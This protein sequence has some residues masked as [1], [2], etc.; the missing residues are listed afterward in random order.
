MDLNEFEARTIVYRRKS[1]AVAEAALDIAREIKRHRNRAKEAVI[2]MAEADENFKEYYEEQSEKEKE[3][4][5][6]WEDLARAFIGLYI[7]EA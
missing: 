4:V 6:I 3:A 5:A 7:E 1:T 2:A